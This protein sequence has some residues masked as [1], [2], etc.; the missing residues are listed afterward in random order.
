MT[1]KPETPQNSF[2]VLLTGEDIARIMQISRA[3]A[4]RLMQGPDL[5]VIRI[6]KMV[7]VRPLDLEKFLRE[8]TT[9]ES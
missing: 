7:R 1:M 4:Y 5:P 3:H 6:G 2:P 9:R 8:H